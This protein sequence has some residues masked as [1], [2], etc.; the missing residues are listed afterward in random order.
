MILIVTIMILLLTNRFS[1]HYAGIVCAFFSVPRWLASGST[2]GGAVSQAFI[3]RFKAFMTLNGQEYGTSCK[4]AIQSKIQTVSGQK[5]ICT[6]TIIY[7]SAM[8]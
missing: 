2:P 5:I 7:Y 8:L 6:L 1:R 4:N 3:L